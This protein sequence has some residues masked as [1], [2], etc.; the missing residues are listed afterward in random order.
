MDA[1][2]VHEPVATA[3]RPPTRSRRRDRSTASRSIQPS[4]RRAAPR[5][6]RRRVPSSSRCAAACASMPRPPARRPPRPAR[7][8]DASPR[9]TVRR[10]LRTRAMACPAHGR[11]P[12]AISATSTNDRSAA[13]AEAA[14]AALASGALV[15]RSATRRRRAG[16]RRS[17]RTRQRPAGPGHDEDDVGVGHCSGRVWATATP[18]GVGT[19]AG[20]NPVTSTPAV[21]RS[22]AKQGTRL[23]EPEDRDVHRVNPPAASTYSTPSSAS[24]SRSP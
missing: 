11:A 15:D 18:A 24:L 22:A 2:A 12:G 4:P 9:R 19:G 5:S 6:R 23:A 7:R 14:R 20:S 3:P 13:A 17:C 8:A 16:G 21:L 1:G 10:R